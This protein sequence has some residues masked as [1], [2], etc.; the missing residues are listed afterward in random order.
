MQGHS[1]HSDHRHHTNPV[2]VFGVLTV[3]TIIEIAIPLLGIAKNVQVPS[4]L[5]ISFTKAGLVA[6]YY[7][8]LRYEKPI[9]TLIFITP[10]LFAVFLIA[11]LAA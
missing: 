5:A 9:Y 7:M 8:H 3:L 2:V 1:D 4:L 11:T 10:A 6:A